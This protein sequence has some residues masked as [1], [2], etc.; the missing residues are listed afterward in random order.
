MSTHFK[1]IFTRIS[2][3]T[4]KCFHG[5]NNDRGGLELYS[6]NDASETNCQRYFGIYSKSDGI[7]PP[8]LFRC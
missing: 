7:A 8:I 6:A 1:G 4:I 3:Y 2:I 5:I